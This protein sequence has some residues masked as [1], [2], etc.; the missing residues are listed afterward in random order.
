M[1]Y[2]G[3]SEENLPPVESSEFTVDVDMDAAMDVDM[4]IP[5]R[6]EDSSMQSWPERGSNT[7]GRYYPRTGPSGLRRTENLG[8]LCDAS[9]EGFNQRN[10]RS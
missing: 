2:G 1:N 6:K 8:I 7:T 5:S 3:S 10:C 4:D 9:E